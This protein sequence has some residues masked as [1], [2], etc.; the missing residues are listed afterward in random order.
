MPFVIAA[1]ILLGVVTFL[2]LI[3]TTAVI[4]RLREREIL[5]ASHGTGTI[6]VDAGIPVGGTVPSFETTATDGTAVTGAEAANKRMLY[7]FF[8]VDCK[9]CWPK[10]PAFVTYVRQLGLGT[11]QV[12]SSVVGAGAASD[13]SVARLESVGR[14]VME[15]TGGPMSSALEARGFPSFVLVGAGGAVEAYTFSLTDMPQ[16]VSP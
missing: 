8:S 5:S 11:D 9:A 15:P 12:V 2:N 16:S 3:L 13:D 6:E 4:R 14:V 7:A 10:V 1:L